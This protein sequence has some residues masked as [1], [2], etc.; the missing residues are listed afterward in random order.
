MKEFS[1]RHITLEE[2]AKEL[3]PKIRCCLDYYGKFK[4]YKMRRVLYFLAKQ[5]GNWLRKRYKRLKSIFKKASTLLRRIY[6]TKPH[7][8]YHCQE[9]LQ[10]FRLDDKSRVKREFQARLCERLEVKL[11]LPTRRK[12]LRETPAGDTHRL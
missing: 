12:S 8:Y 3:N 1:S 6:R 11:L 5:V 2:M 9:G 7:L 10:S 4:G